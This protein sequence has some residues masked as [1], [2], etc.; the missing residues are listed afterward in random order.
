MEELDFIFAK[1]SFGLKY[2]CC[3]PKVSEDNSKIVLKGARHPLI[4][5]SKVVANTII[6]EDH[7]MLLI[8]G[9]NTGGKTVTLKTVG[10]LSLMALLILS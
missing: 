10:L 1:A 5:Q 9:S 6:L 4:D 8:S 3:I 7:K 2:D